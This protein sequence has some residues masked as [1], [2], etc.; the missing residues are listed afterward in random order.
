MVVQI[1]KASIK[2]ERRNL[3]L[4]VI[5]RNATQTRAEEGCQ[6]YQVAEVLET[7]N[8]F[9][10]VELWT[11]LDAVKNHFRAQFAELMAALGDVFAAPPEAFIYDV[12]ATLTLE[13]VLAAAGITNKAS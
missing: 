9:V 6:G 8:S 5:Q 11:D 12:A 7:P 13:E 3:W 4:E 2:R 10:I 1:V